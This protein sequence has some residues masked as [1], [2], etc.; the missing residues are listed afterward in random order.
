ML[1]IALPDEYLLCVFLFLRY[2]LQPLPPYHKQ[3]LRPHRSEL[4]RLQFSWL[5]L[6]VSVLVLPVA[7]FAWQ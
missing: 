7:P 1:L 3:S 4:L 2:W 5:G 6:Q